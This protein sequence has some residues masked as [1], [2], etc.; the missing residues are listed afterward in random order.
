MLTLAD[1]AATASEMLG[2]V[3]EGE[4]LDPLAATL[5]TLGCAVSVTCLDRA[6]ID[7]AIGR[8]FA[9]GAS[10]AQVQEIIALVSGLGVHS[11]M[12]SAG[13][14][15]AQAR[16]SG[17]ANEGPLDAERQALWDKHVGEDPYWLPFEREVPGFLDALLRTSPDLFRG[18]FAYCSIPWKTG[19]VRA[20][21][22]ELAALAVDASPT[23]RFMPGFRLHLRNAI[24]LGA[25]R[26]AVEQT[27]EI[28]AHA[29]LH[30]GVA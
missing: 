21:V 4:P 14:V 19:T 15:L 8:A 26:R 2:D 7:G 24:L 3:P 27:L 29:P 12:V 1:V 9:Q 25:G 6:A 22:K 20:L 16:A 13:T 23:H 30:Q 18:F 11:L 5:I 10:V 28:A 17:L